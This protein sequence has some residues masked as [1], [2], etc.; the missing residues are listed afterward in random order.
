MRHGEEAK[1]GRKGRLAV[2]E[3][4]MGKTDQPA[5]VNAAVVKTTVVKK[6]ANRRLYNTRTSSYVT[7]EDLAALVRRG[8]DFAVFDARSG[9]DIT[10]Q[11]LT[12]IV[13]EQETKGETLLPAAFL[14][15]LIA[16]YGD[17]AEALVPGFLDES[18]AA[19]ARERERF[20]TIAADGGGGLAT[21]FDEV[22]QRTT[23]RVVSRGAAVR[24]LASR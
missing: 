15:R 12:Q 7:L 19:F 2:E 8:E 20:S 18:I 4:K 21:A 16:L 13:F 11:V 17:K 23:K 6:Y 5:A 22:I 24:E 9:D 1:D 14:K 3:T 10:R